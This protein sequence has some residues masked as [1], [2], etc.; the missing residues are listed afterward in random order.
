M[1]TPSENADTR[2][3]ILL[4]SDLTGQTHMLFARS[5]WATWPFSRQ[6]SSSPAFR[7]ILR[8]YKPLA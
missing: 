3:T 6:R 2:E 8:S 4:D 7:C 5:L 1:Q